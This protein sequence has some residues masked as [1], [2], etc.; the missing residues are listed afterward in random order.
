MGFIMGTGCCNV[1]SGA[2]LC[3]NQRIQVMQRKKKTKPC[4]LA[5]FHGDQPAFMEHPCQVW[6]RW[7][8][9]NAHVLAMECSPAFSLALEAGNVQCLPSA[10]NILQ[11]G[12]PHTSRQK[13]FTAN[14]RQSLHNAIGFSVSAIAQPPPSRQQFITVGGQP[15][16]LS[17]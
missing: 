1:C 12:R 17:W 15:A 8:K 16:A 13:V 2:K 6:L 11:G 9:T 4:T 3:L 14:H 7:M 10:V 5:V